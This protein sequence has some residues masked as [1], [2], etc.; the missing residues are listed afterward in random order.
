L[1]NIHLIHWH[2]EE[3]NQKAVPLKKA[4]FDVSWDLPAGSQFLKILE[5]KSIDAILI[6]L[7]RLPSQGR[8]LAINIRKRKGTRH[9]PIIF[10]GGDPEKVKKIQEILPDAYY[11]EW[12]NV[13]DI[14]N[15]A[16]QAPVGDVVVPDSAFAAYAGKPL[17]EKLGIKTGYKVALFQQDDHFERALGK[18]P[19]EASL[20]NELTRDADLTICFM[21]SQAELGQR[22]KSIVGASKNSPVWI[23]W[24]KKGSDLEGDL[25]QTIVRETGLNAGMVDYKICSIDQN[26]SALLFT[27]RG[28]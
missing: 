4:G 23:A 22:L 17:S 25:T 19:S 9:I 8:D 14:V 2:A 1:T 15:D 16:S 20:V 28:N 13:S 3:A 7:S 26:W 27:W 10:V 24:P 6:D 11:C 12:S 18:L 21:R 5:Q